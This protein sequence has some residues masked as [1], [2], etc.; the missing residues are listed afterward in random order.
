VNQAGQNLNGGVG[1]FSI[2]A[3]RTVMVSVKYDF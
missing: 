2:G 3:P 1:F